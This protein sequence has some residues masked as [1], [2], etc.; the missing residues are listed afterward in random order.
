MVCVRSKKS[1]IARRR[2]K[3]SRI[4]CNNDLKGNVQPAAGGKSLKIQCAIRKIR[5]FG[6]NCLL[7]FCIDYF[8]HFSKGGANNYR[9][10]VNFLRG[11][12]FLSGGCAPPY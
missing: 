3:F 11:C 7:N 5:S 4:L 12:K 2:L 6:L 9:R 1:I 8:S 10:G